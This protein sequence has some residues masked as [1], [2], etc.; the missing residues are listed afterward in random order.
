MYN[1]K[2]VAKTL[3]KTKTI[4]IPNND[5][6]ENIFFHYFHVTHLFNLNRSL[7]IKDIVLNE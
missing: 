3:K 6:L 2:K 5:A 7:N 4:L 1:I